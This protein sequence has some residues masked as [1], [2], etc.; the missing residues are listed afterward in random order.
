MSHTA[1]QASGKPWERKAC[2]DVGRVYAR[3]VRLVLVLVFLA[4][5]GIFYRGAERESVPDG[6]EIRAVDDAGH[7]TLADGRTVRLFGLGLPGDPARRERFL[8]R[9]RSNVGETTTVTDVLATDPPAVE[10]SVA[11][12]CGVC[13]NGLYSWTPFQEPIRVPYTSKPLALSLAESFPDAI[14][15][16]DLQD[17]RAPRE[18]VASY[19]PPPPEPKRPVLGVGWPK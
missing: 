16:A 7:I 12:Y 10:L 17:P 2:T 11:R 5:C 15:V 18:R 8:T 1:R 9:L 13:G 14:C 3:G 19:P 4:G 6:V